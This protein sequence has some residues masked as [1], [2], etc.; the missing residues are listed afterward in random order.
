MNWRNIRNID[1]VRQALKDKFLFRIEGAD[2][3]VFY[4]TGNLEQYDKD[5][6]M[7]RDPSYCIGKISDFQSVYFINI[8]EILF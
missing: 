4:S 3:S 1:F 2:G 5:L 8:N 7:W 6:Y